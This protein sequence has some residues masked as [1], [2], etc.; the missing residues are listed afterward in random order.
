MH[1]SQQCRLCNIQ[2]LENVILSNLVLI[3]LLTG[4]P[5]ALYN[6]IK[7]MITKKY[8]YKAVQG[9]KMPLHTPG[10]LTNIQVN[11]NYK[12]H[13]VSIVS[14]IAPSPDWFLGIYDEDFCDAAKGQWK[15]YITKDLQPWDAGTDSGVT[16]LSPDAATNPPVNIFLI[17]K[18][19]PNTPFMGAN[20]IPKLAVMK[21]K[22]VAEGGMTTQGPSTMATAGSKASG[23]TMSNVTLVIFLL[24]GY[25]MA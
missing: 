5:M 6:E 1:D 13:L 3:A 11:V 15:P 10:N 7:A 21:F 16:F 17:T 9:P 22:K 18:D 8:A 12:Y 23:L 19:T 24:C 2:Q 25:L 20:N 4:N 14:M